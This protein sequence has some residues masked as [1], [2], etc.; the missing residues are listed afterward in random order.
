MSTPTVSGWPSERSAYGLPTRRGRADGQGWGMT[1]NLLEI[2]NHQPWV[3]LGVTVV[4][5]L[6]VAIV[7]H[8]LVRALLWRF[9]ESPNLAT[10]VL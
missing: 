6:L 5:A 2:W 4:V 7:V 10:K 9:S 1:E 8:R 3:R